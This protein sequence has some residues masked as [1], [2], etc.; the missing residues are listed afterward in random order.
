VA[1]FV[2]VLGANV[3]YG[4]A[5]TDL[6]ATMATRRLF[7]PHWS[8][9]ILDEVTRNLDRRPV[10][11]YAAVARRIEHVNRA[12]PDA[13]V[14]VPPSLIEAMPINEGGRHVLA[15]AVHVGAQAS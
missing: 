12:L 7:R 10:L 6:R 4:I 3:L 2:V 14:P 9:Q 13:L 11:S 1:R 5:V 15:L 8:A